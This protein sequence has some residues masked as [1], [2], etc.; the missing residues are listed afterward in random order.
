MSPHSFPSLDGP[1]LAVIMFIV[2]FLLVARRGPQFFR[3]QGSFEGENG[4]KLPRKE[5][6]RF[7]AVNRVLT[8]LVILAALILL[9]R[10]VDDL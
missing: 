9:S 1:D 3:S 4:E 2:L 8:G 10:L 7:V 5:N 6:D